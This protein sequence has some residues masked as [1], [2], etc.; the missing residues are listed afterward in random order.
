MEDKNLTKRELQALETKKRLIRS[1]HEVFLKNGFNKTTISEIIKAAGVGYG[2]AYVYFKNKD[3][4]FVTVMES[5]MERFLQ[6]ANQNFRPNSVAAARQQIQN[7]VRDFLELAIEEKSTLKVV[8]EAIGSSDVVEARWLEIRNQFI[9]S[10]TNDITYSQ[11]TNLVSTKFD[12]P[13][14]AKSWYFMNEMFLWECVETEEVNLDKI[15]EQLSLLY[16]SALYE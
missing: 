11:T 16:T 10:I 2:T 1:A 14:A 4:M 12:A 8:K 13:I 3:A 7:Q 9:E 15:V 5:V 6:V